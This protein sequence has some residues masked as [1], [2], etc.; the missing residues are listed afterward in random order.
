MARRYDTGRIPLADLVQEGNMGLMHAVDRFDHRRGLRFSTY[1]AW[2]IRH[3]LARA[4]AKDSR[5]IRVPVHTLAAARRTIQAQEISAVKIGRDLSDDELAAETGF[6]LEKVQFV[7]QH[8]GLARPASLDQ[9]VG[10]DNDQTLHEL[11]RGPPQSGPEEAIDLS[12]WHE[13]LAQIM[14]VLTPMEASILQYRFGLEDDQELTLR[15]IGDKYQLSRE[16]IRQIQNE[17]LDKL[18]VELDVRERSRAST[19][20][21]TAAPSREEGRG[22][23]STIAHGTTR[24]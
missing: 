23:R 12:E 10:R 14:H 21:A 16:R 7:K 15:Q 20:P 22:S 6:S 13:Q 8:V 5:L 3:C 17:A 1:A 11:L 18:R 24:A 19:L 4:V 9:L 2:W